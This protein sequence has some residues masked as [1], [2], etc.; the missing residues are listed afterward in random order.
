MG[1]AGAQPIGHFEAFTDLILRSAG[2]LFMLENAG[3]V[4]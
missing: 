4:L 2:V 3:A 1:F